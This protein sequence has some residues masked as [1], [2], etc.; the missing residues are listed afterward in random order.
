MYEKVTVTYHLQLKHYAL[1]FQIWCAHLWNAMVTCE[2][3]LFKTF[4]SLRRCPSEIILKAA[5]NYFRFTA[6]H[7][8]FPTCSKIL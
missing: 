8:Y 6:A 3:K 5:W 2:I 7:E 4:F 1:Q